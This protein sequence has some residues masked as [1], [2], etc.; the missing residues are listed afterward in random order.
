V[1]R[2]RGEPGAEPFRVADPVEVL[3]EPQPRRLRN[4]RSVLAR[5]P[6]RAR[7]RPDEAGEAIDDCL[8]GVLIAGC[9]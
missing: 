8:P 1:A 7:R 9:S 4:V 6:V 5:E 3:D 2:R